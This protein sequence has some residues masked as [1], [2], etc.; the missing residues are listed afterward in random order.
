[1][2]SWIKASDSFIL[3]YREWRAEPIQLVQKKSIP[4]INS[5][6]QVMKAKATHS[7][8]LFPIESHKEEEQYSLTGDIFQY[9]IALEKTN[10]QLQNQLDVAHGNL[11][12]SDISHTKAIDASRQLNETLQERVFQT[13]SSFK[14]A[15]TDHTLQIK[16]LESD[17]EYLRTQL[18]SVLAN[19]DD[20]ARKK[21]QLAKEKTEILRETRNLEL[22]D[23]QLIENLN[24]K[25]TDLEAENQK[26]KSINM[27]LNEKTDTQSNELKECW[28][29]IQEL[30]S[31][32]QTSRE[33]QN[34][35]EEQQMVIEE[36]RSQLELVRD[37]C[38]HLSEQV[39]Q[40][41]LTKVP[42]GQRLILTN[43]GW[44][45]YSNITQDTLAGKSC[46]KSTGKGP[47][48]FKGR[49]FRPSTSQNS[50]IY[51]YK[52]TNREFNPLCCQLCT[53]FQSIFITR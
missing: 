5:N 52:D 7:L 6:Q 43:E 8:R 11:K 39:E 2:E 48:W 47:E 23:Q 3:K 13:M 50:S 36:L 19:A 35:Y 32:L 9:L 53:I 1:M 20:L 28:D 22:N 24:H 10:A 51:P 46:L 15:E 34:M 14:K 4:N 27:E 38:Q 33:L 26:L 40:V 31:E 37:Q 41:E 25:I 21:D 44:E 29:R 49:D 17:I 42:S 18:E 12:D 45:W 30:H 16:S